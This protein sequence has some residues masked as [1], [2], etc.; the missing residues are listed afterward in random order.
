MFKR[1]GFGR[2]LRSNKWAGLAALAVGIGAVAIVAGEAADL[3][4]NI[5]FLTTSQGT[6]TAPVPVFASSSPFATLQ[7]DL[8]SI[9]A[10]GTAVVEVGYLPGSPGLVFNSAEVIGLEPETTLDNNFTRI[11]T[12]VTIPQVGVVD[13]AVTKSAWPDPVSINKQ[14]TYTLNVVNNGPSIATGVTVL[15][16]LPNTL[17]YVSSTSSHGTC[18]LAA[19]QLD[20][21]CNI[22]DLPVGGRAGIQIIVQPH[23]AGTFTNRVI[24]GGIEDDTDT[25]NNVAEITTTVVAPSIDLLVTK[26]GSPDPVGVGGVVTYTITVTNAGPDEANGVSLF[27]IIDASQESGG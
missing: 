4:P 5:P 27:D 14:L 7:C 16:Q 15:D 25:T 10:G 18:D 13:L 11:S 1:R 20:V 19:D 8:G 24:V 22:G 21:V 6:C 12:T 3:H 23:Y 26:S 2:R 17:D 9:P